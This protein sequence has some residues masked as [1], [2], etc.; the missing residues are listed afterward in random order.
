MKTLLLLAVTLSLIIFKQSLFSQ[1]SCSGKHSPLNFSSNARLCYGQI[2]AGTY[3]F[4][5]GNTF[6]VPGGSGTIDSESG[7][8]KLIKNHTVHPHWIK[9][10]LIPATL[11]MAGA[12]T[13]LPE[14]YCLVSKYNLTVSVQKLFPETQSYIDD[15]LRFAPL[16]AVYGLKAMGVRS[17]SDLI[18]QLVITAKS[19]LLMGVIVGGIKTWLPEYTSKGYTMPSGH[20]AE[21]FV[22]AAILDMEYRDISPWISVSGYLVATTT[23]VYRILNHTHWISDVL[24]G[25]GIGIFATKAVYYTHRYH[26][27]KKRNVVILP[28]IY[29]NGG[30]ISCA[31]VL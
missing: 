9:G 23:G 27:G 13:L 11:V 12:L 17:R 25:A 15:Y 14:S 7:N 10:N 6:L 19:E 30:G 29:K 3:L 22:S 4:K 26:W 5:T 8:I 16:A 18:N 20:T 21:A 31:M 28:A 24:V 1:T 2:P